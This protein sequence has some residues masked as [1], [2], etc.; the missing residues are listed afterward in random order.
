MAYWDEAPIDGFVTLADL[1]L[2]I[3]FQIDQEGLGDWLWDSS[4][5]E[6]GN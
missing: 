3:Q 5:G 4:D 6:F 1:E 2:E